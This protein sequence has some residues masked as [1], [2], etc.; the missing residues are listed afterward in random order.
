MEYYIN[1]GEGRRQVCQQF[2]L[3]T[4]NISQTYLLYNI[5]HTEEGVSRAEQRTRH[6]TNKYNE[7][8]YNFAKE[9]I[10]KLP[11]LPSHYSRKNTS[12]LYLPQ[13]FRNVSNLYRLYV[14]FCQHKS[15]EYLSE[16]LFRCLFHNEYNISFHI[17]KKDKCKV[18]VKNENNQNVWNERET[19]EFI[20]HQEEK[21]ACY[22]RCEIHR[23][24]LSN[25]NSIVTASFDLQK[26]LNTPHGESMLLYYSRKYAVY[27]LTVY[28]SNTQ[29][30]FCYTWGELDGKRGSAEIGTCL[31]NYLVEV[32]K[33][34]AKYIILY[35][36]S[37][38]GQNKNRV[39]LSIFRY[40][41]EISNNVQVIQVNYLLPGHTYMPVDSMHSVIEREIRNLIVW[42]P[43]QWA[44]FMLTAR[45][46]PR[47]Y[48]VKV[49]DHAD[50]IDWQIITG[51]VFTA[52]TMSNKNLKIR[53]IR[54]ATF[55]KTNLDV[56]EIKYSMKEDA[57]C[58]KIPLGHDI[59]KKMTGVKGK[60]PGKDTFSTSTNTMNVVSNL[61]RLYANP[62]PISTKKYLDLKRL[63]DDGVIPKQYVQ[64]YLSLP[65]IDKIDVL[66]IDHQ[67]KN[68]C[69]KNIEDD[70]VNLENYVPEPIEKSKR[71][72]AG[73]VEQQKQKEKRNK[74]KEISAKC[75]VRKDQVEKSKLNRE[76]TNENKLCSQKKKTQGKIKQGI[77]Q[78]KQGKGKAN[79]PKTGRK[80]K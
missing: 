65:Y 24:I 50:F 66:D 70:I 9:Y 13:E 58:Y 48:K 47:P 7:V 1:E 15:Q 2:I 34:G 46:S 10:E 55:K 19:I 59:K 56:M 63:C 74:N 80:K 78:K 6:A 67:D 76:K 68:E 23:N 75:L 37:C 29:N 31:Y 54:I 71:T 32:E 4:L 44:T 52:T 12:K 8:T 57:E 53:D 20:Q 40:F 61:P 62:L 73:N 60:R 64:D 22:K 38:G 3:K 79:E 49:L 36:D 30:G 77:T 45:K 41:L 27:N 16:R 18:C 42:S 25:D 39:I 69:D 21:K 72:I 11:V 14:K 43:K 35:C 33:R 17:P 28:E 5:S 26:V 51:Q